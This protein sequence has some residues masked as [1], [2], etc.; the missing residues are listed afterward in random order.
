MIYFINLIQ[1]N[2]MNIIKEVITRMLNLSPKNKVAI[3][4]KWRFK[5]DVKIG[6]KVEV[7]KEVKLMC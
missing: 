6:D 1:V 4:T 5:V 3:E 7:I 2:E